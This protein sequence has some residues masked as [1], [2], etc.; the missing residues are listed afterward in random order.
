M[1]DSRDIH[2]LHVLQPTLHYEGSKPVTDEERRTGDMDVFWK[3]GVR[4]GYPL[5]RKTGSKLADEGIHFYDGT[6]LFKDVHETIYFD[7]CHFKG[8]G[9]E[10]FGKAVGEAFL[11]S[12]P[13]P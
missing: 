12:L 8:V 11:K 5:L 9:L 4:L 6:M 1:C 10:I 7:N 13:S 2:Y 3:H